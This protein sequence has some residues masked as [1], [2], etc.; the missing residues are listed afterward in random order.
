MS[1]PSN[2][3]KTTYEGRVEKMTTIIELANHYENLNLISNLVF[4]FKIQK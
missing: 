1:L 3:S 2:S 4:N